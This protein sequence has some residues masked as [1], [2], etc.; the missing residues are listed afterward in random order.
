MGNKLFISNSRD[1][2]R[3]LAVD[4]YFIDTVGEEDMLLYFYIN[5]GAV[6]IGRGQNPWVECNLAAMERDGIQLV[7][8]ITGGGA[9]F[10]DAGNLNFSFIAG[11]KIYNLERQLGMILQAVRSLGIPCDFSGRNDLLA[12]GKKFS[13]N[14]FCQRGYVRQHHGTL[15]LNADL[16]RLQN[17]LNVDPRKLQAKGAKSVRSRVCNLSE[18][19]PGLDCEQMLGALTKAFR[20]EYG[21]FEVISCLDEAAIT[22]YIHKQRSEEWRLGKTPRFDLEIENRFTWGNVQILLTLRQNRVDE[23]DVY[24]D[25]IDVDL[26]QE[27]RERLMGVKFGS[28]SMADA[29]FASEKAQVREVADFVLAQGL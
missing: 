22:P 8:R 17:Y 12:D 26:A 14:A 16:S 9:V 29:L 11:E 7:R 24:S 6:I 13:G 18:Y 2:W 27:I 5:D 15:L 28:K 20:A 19:V 10:H 4:E 3:N 1:G 23:L 21:D 25:A